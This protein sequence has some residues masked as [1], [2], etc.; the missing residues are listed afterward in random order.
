MF[1]YVLRS[2]GDERLRYVSSRERYDT[3]LDYP[4]VL[5]MFLQKY[6]GTWTDYEDLKKMYE[7]G[8]ERL[9]MYTSEELTANP[10]VHDDLAWI[11]SVPPLD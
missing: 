2:Q 9:E 8:S 1:V 11:H 6:G 7:D 10:V 3:T 5:R 4:F